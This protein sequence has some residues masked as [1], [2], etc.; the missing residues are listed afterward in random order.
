[1]DPTASDA[2]PD[3]RPQAGTPALPEGGPAL[4]DQGAGVREVHEIGNRTYLVADV[5]PLDVTGVRTVTFGT[6]AFLG[7]ALGLLP[8]YDWLQ[9]TD[10]VWWWWT[11]VAGAGLGV[12][13]IAYCLRRARH[14]SRG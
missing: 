11:C 8:S 1:M 2:S 7:G 5:E 13:G 9:S 12:V 4:P 14:L 10:R 6:L 3:T